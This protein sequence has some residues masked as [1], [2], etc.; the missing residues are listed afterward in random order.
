MRKS[1]IRAGLETLYFSGMHHVARQFL[2]GAGAIL[3]FHRVRPQLSGNF[4]PNGLLEITPEFLD[5]MLWALRAAD[6]DIIPIDQLSRRLANPEARRFVVLTFD[7]GYRDNKEFAW[8]ILKRHGAPF[9]F[10]VPSAFAEGEGELWWLALEEAIANNN[11]V[12]VTLDGH[13]RLFETV[14]DDGKSHAFSEINRHLMAIGTE[15]EFRTIVHELTTRYAI[16]MRARCR[17]ACMGW[18]EIAAMAADP[19]TTIGAHTITHP[20]LTKLTDEEARAEMAGGA[21][22]IEVHLG[23]KPVHFSYP[24]GGPTAA[25]TREFALA[26][27]VGFATAVTTRPGVIFRD[28]LDYMTALPRISVN[29]EFQRLRYL[30]VLLSGA[31]TALMNRFRRVDAA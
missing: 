24:V 9:T 25:S 18:D 8:P 27:A 12:E 26:A 10:Y 19:L 31:A 17:E 28:H 21:S 7:D 11:S 22:A 5:E 23:Q 30:D 20:I 15:A 29:G 16:D 6:I 13:R 2:A 4:Q 1:V 14:T 3:T